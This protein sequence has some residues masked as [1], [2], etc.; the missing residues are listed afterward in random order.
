MQAVAVI[1]DIVGS[2]D[3]ADRV[4]AQQ[5]VRD[6]FDAAHRHVEPTMPLWATSGDEFQAVYSGIRDALVATALVRLLL[7]GGVDCRFGLGI[8]EIRIVETTQQ[9]LSIQDGSAWWRAREAIDAAHDL[10]SRGQRAVRTA[11]RG[12]EPEAEAMMNAY[13]VLRDHTISRMTPR[14]RRIAASLLQGDTQQEIAARE[15]IS[16]SAVSQ[17]AHKSGA[18]ALALGLGFLSAP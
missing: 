3:L 17:S 5:A 16:Q 6:A 4:G 14:E 12:P 15:K 9:G 11:V 1:I 2:R 13:A 7:I 8:G 18:A 10:Q